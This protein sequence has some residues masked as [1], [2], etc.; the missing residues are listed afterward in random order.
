VLQQWPTLPQT[1]QP[2]T[3]NQSFNFQSYTLPTLQLQPW[4]QQQYQQWNFTGYIQQR[5]GL[6]TWPM[7][8]SGFTGYQQQDLDL[9][10]QQLLNFQQKPWNQYNYLNIWQ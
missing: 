6:W 8:N 4:L 1:W 10:K 9:Q 3:W 2:Q 5:E 7:N